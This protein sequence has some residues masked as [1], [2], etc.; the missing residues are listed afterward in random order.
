MLWCLS[1]LN[2]ISQNCE[3][4]IINNDQPTDTNAFLLINNDHLMIRR[5]GEQARYLASESGRQEKAL[6]VKWICVISD[7]I[8]VFQMHSNAPWTD[9]S[10]TPA[11]SSRSIKTPASPSPENAATPDPSCLSFKGHIA[12]GQQVEQAFSNGKFNQ[13]SLHSEGPCRRR[14]HPKVDCCVRG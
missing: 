13:S 6:G 9:L 2:T 11:A 12:W 10:M 7:D 8:W 4:A 1:R 14:K 3:N 5:S